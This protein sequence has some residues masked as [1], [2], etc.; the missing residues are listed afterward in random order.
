MA[1]SKNLHIHNVFSLRPQPTIPCLYPNCSCFFYSLGGCK[2]HIR[3]NHL[4]SPSPPSTSPPVSPSPPPVPP[5]PPHIPPSPPR[6]P[7]SL[8]STSPPAV[9]NSQTP[10]S[11]SV[12][13]IPL[14]PSVY[15]PASLISHSEHTFENRSHFSFKHFDR[16]CEDLEIEVPT[17]NSEDD[18]QQDDFTG[19]HID[20]H[21]MSPGADDNSDSTHNE[22]H[23]PQVQWVYHQ[24]M[25][26]IYNPFS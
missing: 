13:N 14:S 2:N 3:A 22:A 12:L 18:F 15:K 23:L 10:S 24:Q 6:V 25:N 20:S 5:S 17:L 9:P 7:P 4:S 26:G 21:L 1:K 8:P 11:P 19:A 16:P